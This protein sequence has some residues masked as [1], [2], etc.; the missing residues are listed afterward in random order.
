MK[1]ENAAGYFIQLDGLRCMAILCVMANH[2]MPLDLFRIIPFGFLGVTLFFVLS[3][4]LITNILLTAR[5]NNKL[6]A[7]GFFWILKQFYIRRILRIFPVYY[8]TILGLI[9]IFGFSRMQESIP[10]LLFYMTNIFF[11]KIGNYFGLINHFWT[12]AVEEQFY[13]IWPLFILRCPKRW[14]LKG[15]ISVAVFAVLVRA[16]MESLNYPDFLIAIFTPSCFDSLGAGAILAFLYVYYKKRLE[17]ILEKKFIFLAAAF[18][19]GAIMIISGFVKPLPLADNVF[20]RL[21]Y[22]VFCFFIVGKALQGYKNFGKIILENR[23]A[24][25]LGKISYGLYIFHFFM[26]DIFYK[27]AREYPAAGS[28]LKPLLK[29]SFSRLGIFFISTVLLAT[30]SWY[31]L[32]KPIND[33]KKRIKY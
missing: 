1:K 10:W 22:S 16:Y 8:A 27:I 29:N 17:A 7:E 13:I 20:L 21:V 32:E 14:L 19:S 12:L 33:L 15:M 18:I 26:S 9:L 31:L 6:G 24:V 30:I 3:G 25:Y 23:A 11:I 2:W 5:E 4:F 28:V